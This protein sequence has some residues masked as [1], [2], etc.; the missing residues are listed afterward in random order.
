MASLSSLIY[1][2][3]DRYIPTDGLQEPITSYALRHELQKIAVIVNQIAEFTPQATNVAPSSP[4]EGMIRVAVPPW[5]P[6]GGTDPVKVIY[7]GGAWV[8]L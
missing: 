2:L 1:A 4:R 8:A 7:F 3:V 6:L 5:T